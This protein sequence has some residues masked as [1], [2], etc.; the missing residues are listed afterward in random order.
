MDPEVITN[1]WTRKLLMMTRKKRV[2]T[3]VFAHLPG[4]LGHARAS[5]S[6][7]GHP[8]G[9]RS[10]PASPVPPAPSPLVTRHPG[11]LVPLKKR[12]RSHQ[13]MRFP[14]GLRVLESSRFRRAARLRPERP[15]R[16]DQHGHVHEPGGVRLGPYL[17]RAQG[18]HDGA[19]GPTRAGADR[20]QTVVAEPN[21]AAF[22]K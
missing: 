20:E 11:H 17:G 5:L 12:R 15:V 9:R 6:P 21:E 1:V 7:V 2:R 10:A 22:P 19:G 4:L 13:G 18:A 16:A 3:I 14:G 8:P